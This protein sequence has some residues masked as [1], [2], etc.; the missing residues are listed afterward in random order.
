MAA[1]AGCGAASAAADVV[2]AEN[3]ILPGIDAEPR[4]YHLRPPTLSRQTGDDFV[5]GDS[6][7]NRDDRSLL[8]ADQTESHPCIGQGIPIVQREW[9]E[10]QSLVD[11]F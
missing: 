6:A 11:R 5:R 1:D 3:Q 2:D 7:E 8:V 9:L 10:T 4:T